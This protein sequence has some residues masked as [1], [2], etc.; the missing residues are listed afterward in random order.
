MT[1][2][3]RG[4]APGSDFYPPQASVRDSIEEFARAAEGASSFSVTWEEMLADA[5]TDEAITRS[6]LSGLLERVA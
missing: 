4:A 2:V 5:A 3:R 1:T 6:A